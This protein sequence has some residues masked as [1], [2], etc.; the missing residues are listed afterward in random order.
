MGFGYS[1]R[2]VAFKKGGTSGAKKWAIFIYKQEA[3]TELEVVGRPTPAESPVYSPNKS[4]IWAPEEPPSDC[5]FKSD[6]PGYS[7]KV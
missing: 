4:K 5:M 6:F 7:G 2:E 3:P 1:G